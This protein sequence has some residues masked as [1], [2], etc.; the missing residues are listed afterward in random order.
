MAKYSVKFNFDNLP[1]DAEVEIN[2]FGTF[3]NK[4]TRVLE[5]DSEQVKAFR[6][7]PY[8]EIKSAATPKPKPASKSPKTHTNAT[9]STITTTQL[10]GTN[11]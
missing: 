9:S 1:P 5:L 7:N 6:A 4:T 8:L 11:D 10:S 2:D 3:K